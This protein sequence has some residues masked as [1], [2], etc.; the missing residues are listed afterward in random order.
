MRW[1]VVTSLLQV[2]WNGERGRRL[3]DNIYSHNSRRTSLSLG[4]LVRSL[5]PGHCVALICIITGN[6]Q[7]R[8]HPYRRLSVHPAHRHHERPCSPAP[9]SPSSGF[10]QLHAFEHRQGIAPQPM[11]HS[12][13]HPGGWPDRPQRSRA[14][15]NVLRVPRAVLPSLRQSP[16]TVIPLVRSGPTGDTTM[17]PKR[18]T[19]L[20]SPRVG[21]S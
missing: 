17:W 21:C 7:I 14:S 5:H 1:E 12:F 6:L 19:P 8:S 2:P 3:L 15:A 18:H 11:R 4:H 16:P 20:C 13:T 10:E 9:S